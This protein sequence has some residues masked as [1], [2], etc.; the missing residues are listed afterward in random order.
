MLALPIVALAITFSSVP[1]HLDYYKSRPGD[2]AY[3]IGARDY[4]AGLTLIIILVFFSLATLLWI[5]PSTLNNWLIAAVLFSFVSEKLA[6]ET[7]RRLEFQKAFVGWLFVQIFRSG[8]FFIPIFAALFGA[9]YEISFTLTALVAA[10][11]MYVVFNRVTRLT[12]IL[13]LAAF[14][15]IRYNSI[16]VIGSFLPGAYRQLPRLF[17]STVYPA[18]AHVFMTVAQISQ[19]AA[20][21]FAV[22]YQI[23]YRKIIARKTVMFQRLLNNIMKKFIF[24]ILVFLPVYV[25]LANLVYDV[26]TVRMYYLGLFLIPI[27]LTEAIVFALLQAH[28]GYLPWFA[29]KYRAFNT[30]LLCVAFAIVLLTAIYFLGYVG[31]LIPINVP[32]FSIVVGMVWIIVILTRHFDANQREAQVE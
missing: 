13:S 28:V 1:V 4:M 30:Y 23:P 2:T 7:S 11:S 25:F 26:S 27:M 32:V 21:I 10:I 3:R 18:Q 6:D 5:L 15:V 24:A 22:K 9:R 19:G 14:R 31:I 16:F 8:W 17:V 20:L 12:P 29:N